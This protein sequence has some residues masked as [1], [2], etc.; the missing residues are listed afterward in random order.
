V[1]TTGLPGSDGQ[2]LGEL[3]A[4]YDVVLLKPEISNLLSVG[5]KVVSNTGITNAI[6]YGTGPLV[7]GDLRIVVG[8]NYLQAVTTGDSLIVQ[9]LA[10]TT[11]IAPTITAS[12]ATVTLLESAINALATF[13]I[14][15]YRVRVTAVAQRF[16]LDTTGSA[17]IT[18]GACRVTTYVYTLA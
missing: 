6:P 14:F 13:A 1:A 15:V 3:W 12:T 18:A 7:T 16:V 4:S 17:T 11:I 8:P 5:T 2:V 9:T 10:G